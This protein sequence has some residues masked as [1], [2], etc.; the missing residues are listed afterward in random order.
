MPVL[1]VRALPQPAGVDV[2]AVARRLGRELPPIMGVP[3]HGVFVTWQTVEP[4]L[5]SEGETPAEVQPRDTHPPLVELAAY[6]GRSPETIEKALLTIVEVLVDGLGL[7][8]GNA[9]VRYT[10]LQAGR[11]YSGGRIRR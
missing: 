8:D 9:F 6:T 1:T 4:G 3:P 2:A 10:E 11:I 5:Y 7:G